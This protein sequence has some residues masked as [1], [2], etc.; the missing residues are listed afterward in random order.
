MP[1]NSNNVRPF[2]RTEVEALTPGQMGVYGLF[3]QNRWVYVGSGD[4]RDRLLKHLGGDNPCITEEAATSWI[5][6]VRADYIEREKELIIELAPA[7][8]QRVG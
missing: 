3:K 8:N 4:I 2:S 6:E 1:F 7:C 5:D